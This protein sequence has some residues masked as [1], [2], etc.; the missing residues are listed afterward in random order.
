M[1]SCNQSDFNNS[2]R[3][4]ITTTK[5]HVDFLNGDLE[6]FSTLNKSVDEGKK[7]LLLN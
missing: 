3:D 5:S 6:C 1:I 2:Y 4:E 7:Q